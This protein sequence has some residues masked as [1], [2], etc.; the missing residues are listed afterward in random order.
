V[1]DR[2]QYRKFNKPAALRRTFRIKP[3]R[4]VEFAVDYLIAS[5]RRA[6]ASA[7]SIAAASVF[8]GRPQPRPMVLLTVWLRHVLVTRMYPLNIAPGA[9]ITQ[10][11][12][13][14]SPLVSLNA[15]AISVLIVG[16][17]YHDEVSVFLLPLQAIKG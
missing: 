1:K 2:W 14:L 13:V 3:V 16:G 5:T 10:A 17:C 12:T 11:S 6:S 8:T 4:Q 7:N 15:M 9:G